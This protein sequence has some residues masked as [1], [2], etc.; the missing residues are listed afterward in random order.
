VY[1]G[2]AAA[3]YVGVA[4]G[5]T[6]VPDVLGVAQH[7]TVYTGKKGKIADLSRRTCSRQLELLRRRPR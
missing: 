6:R 1:A 7:G 4:P 2:A 5:D 3:G